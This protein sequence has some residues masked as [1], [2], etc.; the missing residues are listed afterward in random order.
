MIGIFQFFG[1]AKDE[2]LSCG[3]KFFGKDQGFICDECLKSIKPYHPMD[4]SHRLSYVFS[5]RIYGL[6]EGPLKHLIHAIKFE[7]SKGLALLLGRIIREHL[8][9][10]M[11]EIEPDLIT[12]PPLNLR[13]F[14]NRGF[15]HVENILKGAEVPCISLFK[16][17]DMAPP[18][19]R[20]GK[21]ERAKAVMGYKVKEGFVDF[22]EDKRILIVDDLLTTG[23]TIQRLS[24][25]LLSLG[26]RE[27]HAYFVAKG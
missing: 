8:W 22:I 5:Y 2:C 25:L 18:L 14:W 6:Y 10:Y 27:V 15:N 16:R 26:A 3:S 20:L 13:R 7:N 11:E 17:Q 9:E 12:F 21:E 23:S 1:L 4:Y 24:Y 19:A